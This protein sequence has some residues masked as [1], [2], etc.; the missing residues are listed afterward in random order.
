MAPH[1][2]R[3]HGGGQA[4]SGARALVLLAV[5][6]WI[7]C[8]A[9]T[10]WAAAPTPAPAPPA[11]VGQ[12]AVSL[13]APAGTLAVRP[14]ITLD[15][16]VLVGNPTSTAVTVQLRQARLIAGFDGHLDVADDPDPLWTGRVDL[17][18]QVRVPAGG[19]RQVPVRVRVPRTV[20][21]NLYLIGLAAQPVTSS[22]ES[23]TVAGRIVTYL[24]LDAPGPRQPQLT[25]QHHTV[26]RIAFGDLRGRA[27]V[28]NV[29]Q[30][31]S[32]LRAQALLTDRNRQL[33]G[34]TP[35]GGPDRL[36]LPAGAS[37][38]LAYQWRPGGWL[39][40]VRPEL[41]VAY[42][43]GT[44]RL[45]TATSAGRLVLVLPWRTVL[46]AGALLL[47]A[48]VLI[49]RIVQARRLARSPAPLPAA[50]S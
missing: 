11:P 32:Q 29:G 6:G 18:G 10:G 12:V 16:W 19:Q 8:T 31:T 1:R 9:G 41:E 34:V 42:P 7:L 35:A 23:L 43:T 4:R 14:G 40:L 45:A 22:A 33:R 50:P 44:D 17:P 21:P 13:S 49:Y 27:V 46:A 24:L 25:M 47:T 15:T 5:A 39:A 28:A 30:V 36:L 37:R 3:R 2:D 26:P 20:T 48:A 38:T